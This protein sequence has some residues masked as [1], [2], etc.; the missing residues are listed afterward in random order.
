MTENEKLLKELRKREFKAIL[1]NEEFLEQVISF[2][3]KID[4]KYIKDKIKTTQENFYRKDDLITKI[5]DTRIKITILGYN[6]ILDKIK[7]KD[8]LYIAWYDQKRK[9]YKI[10]IYLD[11]IFL[12]CYERVQKDD[13]EKIK[14]L[15]N[16]LELTQEQL[17]NVSIIKLLML[18]G[19]NVK[20]KI[21]ATI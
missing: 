20:I 10:K 3:L 8:N 1:E 6:D 16:N 4:K 18:N 2:A 15:F 13:E 5:T 19:E 7:T 9:E 12:H 17:I 14:K 21:Q 11:K